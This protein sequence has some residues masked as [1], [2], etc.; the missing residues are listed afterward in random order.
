MSK[1][2]IEWVHVLF[3]IQII[4]GWSVECEGCGATTGRSTAQGR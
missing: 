2:L 1:E 4:S 3:T